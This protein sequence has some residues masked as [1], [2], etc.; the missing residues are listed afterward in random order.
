[1]DFSTEHTK[2]IV[3]ALYCALWSTGLGIYYYFKY[4][5][6]AKH[7]VISHCANLF[8]LTINMITIKFC[9]DHQWLKE[10]GFAYVCTMHALFLPLLM[11]NAY[12]DVVAYTN[13][14]DTTPNG[15]KEE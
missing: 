13:K 7:I 8:K 9:F 11:R 1:M 2:I 12:R 4:K 6:E 10:Y 15:D 5:N 3:L 14:K